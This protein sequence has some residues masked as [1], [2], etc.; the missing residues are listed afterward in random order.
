MIIQEPTK[1]YIFQ[2]G[3]TDFIIII[4]IVINNNY[5]KGLVL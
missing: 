3:E 1:Q 2:H 4:I 5:N